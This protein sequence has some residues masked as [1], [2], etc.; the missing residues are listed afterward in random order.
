M[1]RV[2]IEPRPDWQSKVEAHGFHFHT[3]DGQPYWNEAAYYAFESRE[4]DAIEKATYELDRM[5]L[6][7]VECFFSEDLFETFGIDEP[8][9]EWLA[10][11]WETDERTIYGRFDLAYRPGVPPKLLEYNADTPTALLEASVVQWFWLQDVGVGRDQFNSIHERLI[12]AWNVL[13][14]EVEGVVHFSALAEH[15]EDYTTAN[16]LRDTAMQGGLQTDYLAVEEIAWNPSFKSFVDPDENAIA[17]MFKLYPWEW[18]LDEEFGAFLPESST[19]WLEPPWKMILSNKL[20]MALLWRM[21]PNSPYLLRTHDEPFGPTYVSKPMLGREGSNVEIVR[22]NAVAVSSEGEYDGPRIYQELCELPEFD[23]WRPVVGSW[24][25]NGHACGIGI[26]ED[27]G[28]ITG[29]TSR[30]VPHCIG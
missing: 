20:I 19:R 4:I 1:R 13:G 22:D 3:V 11:S 26:R 7:A 18:M 29:N 16:Y 30:F 21:F 28:P 15:V 23:G 25:V 2:A 10:A 12:E 5:C 8:F 9:R 24:M 27:S 17:T 14:K 6:E